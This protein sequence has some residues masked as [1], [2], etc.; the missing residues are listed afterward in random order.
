M[1]RW[2]PF[3]RLTLALAATALISSAA[4]AGT[5]SGIN[6]SWNDC[7]TFGIMQKNFACTAN[8]GS[9]ILY[10]SAITGLQMDQ[11][12]G[13]ASVITLQSNQAAL[14]PWW[15]LQT[16]G[17]RSVALSGG[18]DFTANVSCLD[19]WANQAVGGFNYTAGQ[20]NVPNR[21][22]IKTVC[23]INPST[24]ITGIDEYY[25]AKVTVLNSKST[26]NGSCA[27]CDDGVCLVFNQ[28]QVTQPAGVGDVI[29]QNP[30]GREFVEWQGGGS[31]V[32][33]G[34]PAATP[35]RNATWG[36]VKS[37]YR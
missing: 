30:L 5:T 15:N 26:G 9:N 3:C 1:N 29:L 35:T 8:S 37:L 14:S 18:F 13:E 27:G 22:R 6:L 36:S 28:L 34:C 16:G 10:M 31:L 4:H 2:L 24:G 17:C 20:D 7:G 12:N 33:G 32:T 23:A 11:L 21:G 19:P 25:F